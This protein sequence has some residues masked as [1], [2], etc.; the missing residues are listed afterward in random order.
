VSTLKLVRAQLSNDRGIGLV[1][2][3]MIVAMLAILGGIIAT[4]AVNERR[5]AYNDALH[6]SSLVAADSGT[7][8]AI[9]WLMLQGDPPTVTDW[10]LRTV[11]SQTLSTLSTHEDQRFEYEMNVA[12]TPGGAPNWGPAPGYST[13]GF[14][15]VTYDVISG[16]EAGLEGRSDVAVIV[17]KIFSSGYN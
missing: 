17:S 16:G 8:E 10:T 3:M 2:T 11:G 15:Q 12:L 9:G 6:S 1:G 13:E 4:I 7:E 14:M 5:S